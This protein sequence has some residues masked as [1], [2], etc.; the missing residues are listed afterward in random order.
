MS[1]NCLAKTA[2][3]LAEMCSKCPKDSFFANLNSVL[4]NHCLDILKLKQTFVKQ[5]SIILL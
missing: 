3:H 5:I 2:R 1:N 4:K